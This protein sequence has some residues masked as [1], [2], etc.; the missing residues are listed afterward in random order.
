MNKNN[1]S[2][3]SLNAEQPS[4]STVKAKALHRRVQSQ[5]QLSVRDL[6]ASP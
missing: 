6:H 4:N 1:N 2:H 5:K 3:N